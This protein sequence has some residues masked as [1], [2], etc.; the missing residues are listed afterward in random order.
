MLVSPANLLATLRVVNHIWRLERQ[1]R[2]V[3]DIAKLG[4]LLYDGFVGFVEELEKVR[5]AVGSAG[6]SV[7]AAFQQLRAGRTNLI[8]RAERLQEL[9]VKARKRLPASVADADS[10]EETDPTSDRMSGRKASDSA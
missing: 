5:R 1:N 2:N 10:E 4:A 3:E 8:R 7:D 6:Q 9:G